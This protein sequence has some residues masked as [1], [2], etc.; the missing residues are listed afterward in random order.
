MGRKKS[1][2]LLTSPKKP[3]R[4]PNRGGKR[5]CWTDEAMLDAMNAVRKDGV[6]VNAA[7]AQ[8]GVPT[9]TLR[10]RLSGR[11]VHGNNPGPVPYLSPTE[12]SELVEYL[13]STSRVGYGK[14]RRAAR[15]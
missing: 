10:N 6:G 1:Y 3:E 15:L 8:F 7:A 9:T 2:R 13:H 11:V 12:E 14:T 5:K 4:T